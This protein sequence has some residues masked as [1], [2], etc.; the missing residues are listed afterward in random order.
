MDHRY[1]LPVPGA[2][3]ISINQNISLS[4]NYGFFSFWDPRQSCPSD[5]P[6][7]SVPAIA[8][9]YLGTVYPGAQ[10]LHRIHTTYTREQRN[11]ATSVF[12]FSYLDKDFLIH[13]Y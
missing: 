11:G 8:W 10:M 3:I 4:G 7:F 12:P 1:F 2:N 6:D 13:K 9:L 5:A